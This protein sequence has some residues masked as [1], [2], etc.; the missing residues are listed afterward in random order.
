MRVL[1]SAS[2]SLESIAAHPPF[3]HVPGPGGDQTESLILIT[4][5][6]VWEGPLSTIHIPP[7]PIP[8]DG[9]GVWGVGLGGGGGIHIVKIPAQREDLISFLLE[10]FFA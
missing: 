2:L 6:D 10:I 1:Q 9:G 4:R 8:I 7:Y 5:Q 3:L